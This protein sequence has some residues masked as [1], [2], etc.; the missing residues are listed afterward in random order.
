MDDRG[1][2]YKRGW[3]MNGA[4][5]GGAAGGGSYCS[6]VKCGISMTSWTTV[7]G[8]PCCDWCNPNNLQAS[9]AAFFGITSQNFMD[10]EDLGGQITMP[11]PLFGGPESFDAL[12]I[13]VELYAPLG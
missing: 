4:A 3:E 12:D 1:N 2:I 6:C 11:V 13:D 7:N 10:E 9:Q 5:C 8:L